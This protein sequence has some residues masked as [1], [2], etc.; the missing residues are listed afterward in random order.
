M[1]VSCF[2]KERARLLLARPISGP[3]LLVT[4]L[5][6][7]MLLPLMC[8]PV[9]G[10]ANPAS[11]QPTV[12]LR[13]QIEDP[14]GTAMSAFYKS[15]TRSLSRADGGSGAQ[16]SAP[17]TRILQFGDSHVA[18][19]IMTGWLRR[20]LDGDFGDSGPGYLVPGQPSAIRPNA[21]TGCTT[22]WRPD[23]LKQADLATDGRYGLAG[24]SLS[25]DLPDEIAWVSAECDRFEVDLMKQPLG[26]RAQIVLDGA[27]YSEL[28]LASKKH[29]PLYVQV[30]A[31]KHAI[32][33]IEVVT[34]GDGR[35]RLLGIIAE[36]NQG[37]IVYDALGVNGAR[38]SRPL[39]WDWTSFSDSL[40]HRRPDLIV[41]SYGSNEVGDAD[42][43]LAEYGR[44]FSELL[45]RMH[46][47]APQASLLVIS[48]PDRARRAG[49]GRHGEEWSEIDAMSPLVS[50]QRRAAL[51]CGVAFCD[52]YRAMGGSGSM[53]RWASPAL[54]L[55]QPD[56]VHLT[57]AGYHLV[58]DALYRAIETGYLSAVWRGFEDLARTTLE[59]K[60][61]SASGS[62]PRWVTDSTSRK[63]VN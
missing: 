36:R 29:E 11:D 2:N 48:P 41:V 51:T 1:L 23:G 54:S 53:N 31:S 40:K 52:L 63:A 35:V 46:E 16:G 24:V 25:T 14:Q 57:K 4:A 47:A 7:A 27:V 43:D 60:S 62:R 18:A 58:A 45:R 9:S 30:P 15:L 38:A 5:A 34:T 20:H 44:S 42:L 28:S 22:G 37:G 56:H 21:Q 26:G 12:E 10:P 33:K 59:G 6:L 39:R 17:V 55:A 8:S 3:C 13:L 19:D 61:K 32:H 49:D 50:V